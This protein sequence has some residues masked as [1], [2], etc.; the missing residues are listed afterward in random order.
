[1]PTAR[2]GVLRVALTGG[3]GTGKSYVRAK[4][5]ALGVPTIDADGLVHELLGP[6]TRVS[7]AVMEAFGPSVI[8]ADG[9]V[10]RQ[11]LG[12]VVFADAAARATLEAIVH[13]AVY[14]RIADWLACESAA[15]S[16]LAV[17]DIP[18]LFETGREGHFDRVVVAACDP[19][20]QIQRVRDRDSLPEAAARARLAAQWPIQRKVER[21][22]FVIWTDGTFEETDRQVEDVLARL[23]ELAA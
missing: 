2:S 10:D 23:R 16:P 1:M 4:M 15:G 3:I 17:A 19:L 7:G 11:A 9:G 6:G 13:P 21:A 12:R 22:H 14:E 8:T 20:L 18:L 5:A